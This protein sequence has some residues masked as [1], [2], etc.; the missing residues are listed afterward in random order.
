MDVVFDLFRNCRSRQAMGVTGS[1][2]FKSRRRPG[3]RVGNAITFT[4]AV[5]FNPPQD[6]VVVY[7][8]IG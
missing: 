2:N 3:Q 6:D 1:Q 7:R 4:P 5:P 8:G